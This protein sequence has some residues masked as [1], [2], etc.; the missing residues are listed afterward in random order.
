MSAIITN[1]F[2]RKS[3]ERFIDELINDG[4]YF[5]GLGKT[6]KW[7]DTT[8]LPEDSQL[9]SPPLPQATINEDI[10]IL[11]N[12]IS[13]VKVSEQTIL[14][15]RNPWQ[16]GRRYK[17]YDPYDP[18]TFDLEGNDYPSF[19]TINDNVYVCLGNNSG[20]DSTDSPSSSY[21]TF[22]TSNHV[23][24]T[25]DGYIWAFVQNNVVSS[26]FYTDEFIPVNADLGS[27]VNAK[28]ATGGLVYNFKIENGGQSVQPSYSIKLNGVDEN[29]TVKSTID[30]QAD[31]RFTVTIGGAESS[32]Q[33]IVYDD[34]NT[35]ALTGYVKA[36]VQVYNG[37]TLLDS[38]I[39]KPLVAPID[40]FGARPRSDLPSF[41]AGCYSRFSGTVDGE[42]IVD[43]S[44]RQL[45]LIK[46]PQRSLD[47]PSA[48]DDGVSYAD[49]DA[50]D[51][52]NYIQFSPGIL[53]QELP[54]GSIISQGDALAYVDKYDLVNDRIYYH[55]NSN[56]EVNYIPLLATADITVTPSTGTAQT[57]QNSDISDIINS[58]YIHNTGDVVFIDHRKKITRNV[59]QTEDVKIV[60]QF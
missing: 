33:S 21:N 6:D 59:D 51:A 41:Y 25:T 13:L 14:I 38:I 19:V 10:D 12:L 52:L 16:S 27:T 40:G 48:G 47:S 9:F 1:N 43:A 26:K 57:Y 3:C 60:I 17:I 54:S 45:S 35:D 31:S 18:L 50:L 2:R 32:I 29:G 22:D 36:S 55:T 24:E 20:A 56:N 42:A 49:E 30:L 11:D 37:T 39:I 28:A 8:E 53:T 4:D 5:I 46:N 7:P 23:L 58:E 34:I 44:F 15:P